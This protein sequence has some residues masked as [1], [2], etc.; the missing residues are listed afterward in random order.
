MLR[1]A[2]YFVIACQL[3]NAQNTA[4]APAAEPPP[5]AGDPKDVG[6]I[7]ALMK[8]LY[9][10]ISGPAGQERNWERARTLFMPDVRMIAVSPDK[11]GKPSVRMMSF[12]EYVERVK[13]VFL[14]QGFY[15]SEIKRSVRQ[16][17]NVAQVFTS[18]ESRHNPGEE[19]L[20]RGLNAVQVYFDGQRWWIASIVWD[21]DRPGNRL[22]AELAPEAA[23]AK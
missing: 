4:P 5:V 6:S 23:G 8:A 10:V 18:Y 20:A 12:P 22:P 19:P 7:D 2:V 3:G 14:K 15:E 21:T 17:G 13:P 16:F 11:A 1:T 9:Q